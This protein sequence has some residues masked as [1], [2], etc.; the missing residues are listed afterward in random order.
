MS[1]GI[2]LSLVGA[3]AGLVTAASVPGD[4]RVLALFA[5]LLLLGAAAS[6]ALLRQAVRANPRTRDVLWEPAVPQRQR[7]PQLEEIVQELTTVLGHGSDPR[8]ELAARI[9]IVAAA[10][11]ADRRGIELDG[12]PERAR[13]AIDDE[14]TWALVQPRE[15][16]EPFELP[17]LGAPELDRVLASVER[18]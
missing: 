12:E 10:R 8:S 16:F 5:Y 11:L 7:V 2:V 3:T 4:D 1:S 17:E 14:L 13:A 6:A 15:R 9:R 18:I